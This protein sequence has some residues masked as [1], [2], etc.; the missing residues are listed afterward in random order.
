MKA[1][2]ARILQKSP[3]YGENILR[4]LTKLGWKKKLKKNGDESRGFTKKEKR[5]KTSPGTSPLGRE[6]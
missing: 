2:S 5:R 6:I 4:N 3:Y 1:K